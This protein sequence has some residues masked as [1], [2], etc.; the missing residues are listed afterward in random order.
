MECIRVDGVVGALQ[1]LGDG[2]DDDDGR[3]LIR[4]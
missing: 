1:M 2:D 3:R 4:K